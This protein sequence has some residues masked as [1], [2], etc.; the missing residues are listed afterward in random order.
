MNKNKYL[1]LGSSIGVLLLLIVAAA[2]D[3]LREWRR[4]QRTVHTD[5][6]PIEIRIRQV[7]S[8]GLETN[9][10]CVSCHIGMDPGEQGIRG[11]GLMSTHKKLTH[12]PA[13][14]GCTVCHGG[15][16]LATE[17]PDAHGD[18]RFWPEPMIPKQFSEAGCG[19][20]HALLRIPGRELFNQAQLTFER[21]DC[22]ACHRMDGRGGTIRPDGLGMEG[23]DLSRTAISGYDGDWYPKHLQESDKAVSGPWKSSFDPIED[24]DLSL[25]SSYL[26]T[27]MGAPKLIEA[28]VLFLAGGCMGCHKVSGVGGDEGPDL[29][30]AGEKDPGQLAF[31]GVQ[32]KHSL[33]N[34]FGE[35]LQSPVSVVAGS[36]MPPVTLD[37]VEIDK[38]TMYTLSLR[39][40]A[41]PGAFLPKDRVRV[42]KF[43][44]REFA[45]DGATIFGAI[46]SGCH[47][48]RGQGKRAPGR[49]TFP[50]IANPDF[51]ELA[52]DRFVLETATQGRPGRKMPAWGMKDGGLNPAEISEAATY[53]RKLGNVNTLPDPK[54]ARWISSDATEGKRMFAESCSGCHGNN[55]QGGEGLALNNTVLLA[56]AT[57]TYLVETISRGR[58]GTAMEGYRTPSPARRT[59]SSAEIEEIVAYIRSWEGEAK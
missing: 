29:T 4:I 9:D 38:L 24:R 49:Q 53:L 23:P 47:G 17:K 1:L 57:D 27:R 18:V 42:E 58:R 19:T 22:L 12:D 5:E 2:Q 55:G 50:A 34:W 11:S 28:K 31:D 48:D 26:S 16:G 21:L 3:G 56:S 43:G 44:D 59:L 10:R 46:C 40:R 33:A 35:H 52:S 39:R 7:V 32:G 8:P 36:L 25:I 37:A 13:E 15:Q 45:A 30:Q 51:L 6:G 54:P 20:C 14:F 41:L